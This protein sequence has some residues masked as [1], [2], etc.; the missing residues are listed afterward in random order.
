VRTMHL[1]DFCEICDRQKFKN[2]EINIVKLKLFPFSLRGKAR[3]WLLSL[4]TAS[5]NSWDDLKEAFIKEY[6]PLVKILHIETTYHP[7]NKMIMNM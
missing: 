5:I 4:P 2:A 7:S 3:E 1:R 6:Y